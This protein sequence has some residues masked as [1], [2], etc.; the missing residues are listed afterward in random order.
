[1]L[2]QY[3]LREDP[4]PIV[5]DGKVYNWAGR[6]ELQEDLIDL[7]KGV[8]AR[9]IGV[10][11]FVILHGELGAGKSHALRF[12]KTFVDDETEK[13]AGEFRSLAI[14]IERPRVAAKLNFLELYKYIIKTIGKER[15]A[16]YCK[17][18]AQILN[19]RAIEIREE[20]KLTDVKDLSSFHEKAIQDFRPNDKAMVVLLAKGSDNSDKVYSFFTGDTPCEEYGGKVDSDFVAAKV[21][22]DLFRVL[23]TDSKPGSQILESVYLF[24]DE[25]EMLVESKATETELVF[26]GLR[27]LINGLPYRFGLILSFSVGTALIEAIMNTHLLKRLTRQY[28]EIPT[29][30]DDDAVEFL[31][32]QI[33]DYR[34]PDAHGVGDFY[35]F[36]EDSIRYI[37]TH[38]NA[39]TPRNLFIDCK[40]VLERALRKYNLEPGQAI[41]LDIAQSILTALR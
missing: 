38:A 17:A 41:T 11:E 37:V 27:E 21:L 34:L 22:G 12:L 39:M 24:I 1:M 35:P 5:P 28:I 30:S 2:Q 9:D 15:I 4:F 10:S 33:K 16:D 36:T 18:I 32:A 20:S 14:Y 23:T 29:L 40:R 26:S 25:C 3:S 31:R 13:P 6:A 19:D 7:V 8:R